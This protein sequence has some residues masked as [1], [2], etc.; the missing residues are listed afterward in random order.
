MNIKQA[1]EQIEGAVR[2]YMAKDELGIYLIPPQM[3]RPIF[4]V[5]P[6]GVGK[7][8]IVQQIAERMGINFVSYSMTH[9]TRQS[10]IG[11]PYI[12]EAEYGGKSY[13]VSRYT[14][15]EII[16]TVYD[17][18]KATGI[19][20]GILFLDEVNC[21]S[22][23]L[24]P[25]M[26]QFLQFKSFGQHRL[27][28]GWTIVTAG[29]PPEYNRAARDFD[30]ATLDRMKRIDVEPDLGIW[31]D[32]AVAHQVHPAIITYL[33]NKPES[34]YH[35]RQVVDGTRLVT[36]RGW[37]DLSRMLLAYEQ[38]GLHADQALV[39]QY[40]QDPD[41]AEDFSLYLELFAKYQSDCRVT[42]ILD[43]T[44]TDE[45]TETARHAPFDE[46]VAIV[47]LLDSALLAR[48]HATSE[49]EQA[50]R[51]TRDILVALRDE[52][53]SSGMVLADARSE[54]AGLS[55]GE[56]SDARTRRAAMKVSILSRVCEA[57]VQ[58]DGS[59]S[60]D[61]GKA[62]F[63]E[64][65][66]ELGERIRSLSEQVDAALNFVD[67]TYGDGEE[68][69]VFVTRLAVDPDFMAFVSRHGSDS[70][71]SHSKGLMVR[72]RKHELLDELDKL[73]AE[74]PSAS[75]DITGDMGEL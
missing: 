25:A 23:T 47:S 10:A 30:P 51:D 69:L 22:E 29:N 74:A 6:P 58:K 21:V 45:M 16:A 62:P 33:E 2:S 13:R 1:T 71:V 38:V 11:L 43:G 15:S 66:H 40:I 32:Y 55:A 3:Q 46:R 64:A 61:K 9:H 63:N 52:P 24:A 70:F 73:S 28:S 42:D 59:A 37:D 67:Q 35:V 53:S 36:A 31:R 17:V 14:M 72:D 50:I 57:M 27:P 34:F 8:A 56:G 19:Q 39:S 7:T 48:V 54:L 75:G 65:V 4:L 60:L 20:E 68:M 49:Y 44:V 18:I 41:I 12:E 26:L 5:G